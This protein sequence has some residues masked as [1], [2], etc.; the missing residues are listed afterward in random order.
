MAYGRELKIMVVPILTTEVT[1]IA[2]T[3]QPIFREHF[4][5]FHILLVC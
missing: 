1:Q 2:L 3:K 4:S 5:H